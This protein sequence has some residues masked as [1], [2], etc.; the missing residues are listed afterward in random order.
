MRIAPPA[1]AANRPVSR[2]TPAS[3]AS[4]PLLPKQHWA[5]GVELYRRRN[6]EHQ[7]PEHREPESR[8]GDADDVSDSLSARIR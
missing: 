7:R 4:D 8:H 2:I 6:D 5:G 1:F 3:I